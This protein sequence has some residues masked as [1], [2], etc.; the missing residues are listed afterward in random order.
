[1]SEAAAAELLSA[2]ARH[3]L[4]AAGLALLAG[5]A[6]RLTRL[7]AVAHVLW[8][9]VLLKL[10]TPPLIEVAVLPAA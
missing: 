10:L 2:L 6:G 1:M 8:L 9:A 5:A 3:A 4:A 7:P